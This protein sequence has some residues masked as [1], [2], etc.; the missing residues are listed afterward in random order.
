MGLIIPIL[1]TR[2]TMYQIKNR[3]LLSKKYF[4]NEPAVTAKESGADPSRHGPV[5]ELRAVLDP[6]HEGLLC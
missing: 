5:R 4:I 3:L 1:P 6:L 2:M